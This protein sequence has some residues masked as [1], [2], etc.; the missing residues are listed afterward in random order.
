MS[1]LPFL[2]H[3]LEHFKKLK[4]Y[5]EYFLRFFSFFPTEHLGEYIRIWFLFGTALYY[6]IMLLNNIRGFICFES[7]FPVTAAF[8]R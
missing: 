1:S 5:Q 4:C 7:F 2:K 3:A 6:S 8:Y